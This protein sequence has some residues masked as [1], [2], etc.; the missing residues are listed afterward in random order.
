MNKLTSDYLDLKAF[1]E[2]GDSKKEGIIN[3]GD[4]AYQVMTVALRAEFDA[5]VSELSGKGEVAFDNDMGGNRFFA[6]SH[7]EG[8]SYTFHDKSRDRVGIMYSKN[9]TLAPRELGD[10]PFY[11]GERRLLQL[12][13]NTDER[14]FGMC[15]VIA[16]GEGHFIIY[17]G[18]G[19]HSSDDD[20]L[21]DYLKKWTPSGQHPIIDVWVAT[22][23]HWDHLSGFAKF[24]KKYNGEVELKHILLNIPSLDVKYREQDLPDYHSSVNEWLP[25]VFNS[26]PEAKIHK[27][28]SGEIFNVGGVGLEILYTHEMIHPYRYDLAANDT[29]VVSR[30]FINGK[31]VF[32]S[33]DI[34]GGTACR[35]IHHM[36]GSYIKSDIYQVAHH[37]WHSDAIEFYY[38]VDPETVVWPNFKQDWDAIKELN[39]TKQLMAEYAE[40]KRNFIIANGKDDIISFP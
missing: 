39:T 10:K 25:A 36:Y 20:R 27:V 3:C 18:D 4:G 38:D 28:H 13:P 1:V 14:N 31:T 12:A 6:V 23:P 2:S 15:Y 17:D 40:G 33:A 34:S 21:F 35:M 30:I 5:F 16:L 24:S 26:F 19:D 11:S 8:F 9:G 22:H 7:A 29:S 37:G 32:F